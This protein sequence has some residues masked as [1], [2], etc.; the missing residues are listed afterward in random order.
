MKKIAAVFVV[1]VVLFQEYDNEAETLVSGLAINPD[2]DDLD[3]SKFDVNFFFC[4]IHFC[5]LSFD[6]DEGLESWS[7]KGWEC[8]MRVKGGKVQAGKGVNV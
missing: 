4:I 3:I 5:H 6:E 8:V 2:D 7:W 1:A